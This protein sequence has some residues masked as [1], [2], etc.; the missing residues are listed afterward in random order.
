MFA[1]D[2]EEEV[3]LV[4]MSFLHYKSDKIWDYPKGGD[5][6]MVDPK[7]IFLG[8]VVPAKTLK[9]GFTFHEDIKSLKLYNLIKRNNA[10]K[11]L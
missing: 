10:K 6:Q 9:H 1:N 4:E 3:N 2:E 5:V 7:Y 8:P 11:A